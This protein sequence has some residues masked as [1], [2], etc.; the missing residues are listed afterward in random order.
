MPKLEEDG[1]ESSKQLR[2]FFSHKS[3]RRSQPIGEEMGLEKGKKHKVSFSEDEEY[4]ELP[5]DATHMD[6]LESDTLYSSSIGSGEELVAENV[7]EP[8]ELWEEIKELEAEKPEPTADLEIETP[9]E[10][11]LEPEITDDPVRMYLH[12]IGRVRLLTA[13]NEKALAKDVELGK[14]IRELR[15]RHTKRY[16]RA[17]SAAEIVLIILK[18]L[19]RAASVVPLLQKQFDLTPTTN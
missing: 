6:G 1:I 17:P 16:G 7:T 10:G 19:G 3:Q 5:T 14:Y 11:L 8:A 18:E 13:E 9:L 15:Q 4:R 2:E 12:E